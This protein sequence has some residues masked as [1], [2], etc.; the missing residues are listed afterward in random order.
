MS[1]LLMESKYIKWLLGQHGK[2]MKEMGSGQ[3]VT[4]FGVKFN[5]LRQAFVKVVNDCKQ[6]HQE[7]KKRELRQEVYDHRI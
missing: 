7:I 3:K 6:I 1:H 4:V 2:E 5:Q